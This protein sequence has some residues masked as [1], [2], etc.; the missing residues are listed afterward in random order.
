MAKKRRVEHIIK[1]KDGTIGSPTATATTPTRLPSGKA[2]CW[3]K[4]VMKVLASA[5]ALLL[6][7]ACGDDRS[8]TVQS[9]TGILR[10]GQSH[11]AA[12]C[13][14]NLLHESKMSDEGVLKVAFGV[15]SNTAMEDGFD[16]DEIAT[17]LSADDEG[18]FREIVDE[19]AAC[20]D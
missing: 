12:Q 19:F 13:Q 5:C 1:N 18:A 8:E 9:L 6:I 15:G 11:D 3:A 4:I 16:L 7:S 20:T 2:A 14:A 10:V 17:D